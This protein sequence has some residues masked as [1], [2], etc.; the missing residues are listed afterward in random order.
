MSTFGDGLGRNGLIELGVGYSMP[1]GS[2]PEARKLQHQSFAGGIVAPSSKIIARPDQ[3]IYGL[4]MEP[5]INGKLRR[6]PGVRVYGT[7]AI[8]PYI[9][10]QASLD[11]GS[12]LINVNPPNIGVATT[13]NFTQT[14]EGI[15]ATGAR[16]WNFLNYAGSLLFSNGTDATY[17][18]VAAGTYNDISGDIIAR[19][20]AVFRS[21]IFAGGYTNGSY[22][23]LG[24]KWNGTSALIDDWA[25]DG[26]GAELILGNDSIGDRVVALRPFGQDALAVLNRYSLWVGMP[27][28][29]EDHPA[30][31]R[32]RFPGIGCVGEATVAMT[33]GGV[34]F[35]SEQGVVNYNLSEA[36]V[37]SG[38]INDRLLPLL[39]TGSG[40]SYRAAY[41]ASRQRYFLATATELYVYEFPRANGG[42]D[43]WYVRPFVPSS[44]FNF[45]A[46][47]QQDLAAFQ[48]SQ[49]F[50]EKAGSF[51]F[52]H[53]QA[54]GNLGT[55]FTQN[56]WVTPAS[57]DIAL[58]HLVE[59]IG[60]VI[61]YR[62]SS[63]LNTVSLAISSLDNVSWHGITTRDTITVDLP[64][65]TQRSKTVFIPCSLSGLGS[66]LQ[67]ALTL[68]EVQSSTAP[69]VEI[70]QIEQHI[71]DNGPISSL[72]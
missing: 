36:R 48:P 54:F 13:G 60:L 46:Q 11:F 19:T 21:R 8:G 18:R 26:S 3:G 7:G 53:D 64:T 71:L 5:T 34:T 14:N 62:R 44:I 25:G 52:E 9:F 43:C 4:G 68:T 58:D 20:F 35:L 56:L 22:Q 72:T 2:H 65:T 23:A 31:F 28:G 40:G 50:F 67:Y 39:D 63:A 6:S 70:E 69:I 45:T 12:T 41:D 37:I 27:T 1:P 24:I 47:P 38:P 55:V 32:L 42:G 17:E 49:V 33:P 61:T 16:G 57:A 51:G 10:S 30:D 29:D 15:T 66:A 59:T